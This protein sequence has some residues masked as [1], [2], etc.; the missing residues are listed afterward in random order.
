MLPAFFNVL[1]AVQYTS[2]SFKK[3]DMQMKKLPTF[4]KNLIKNKIQ[5]KTLATLF[6]TEKA[7]EKVFID[8]YLNN[9]TSPDGPTK[10]KTTIKIICECIEDGESFEIVIEGSAYGRTS[11]IYATPFGYKG[12]ITATDTLAVQKKQVLEFYKKTHPTDYS[13]LSDRS[14]YCVS[15]EIQLIGD[16]ENGMT[17]YTWNRIRCHF[18]RMQEITR[19][20]VVFEIRQ[21]SNEDLAN[22]FTKDLANLHYLVI[23]NYLS[24]YPV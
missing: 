11:L 4:C 10:G 19:K 13:C 8:N 15:A 16:F 9:T 3:L 22:I 18:V 5:T 14:L 12:M 24:K 17:D 23:K 6:K 20:T 7:F 2:N 1:F 21:I